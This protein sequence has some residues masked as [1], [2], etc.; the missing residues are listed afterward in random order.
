MLDSMS[1]D[2]PIKLFLPKEQ[3]FLRSKICA[4]NH[5]IGFTERLPK[6]P[7]QLSKNHVKPNNV[8][9]E[10]CHTR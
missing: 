4:F 9:P 10:M 2:E 1:K 5:L 6:T 7:Q 3:L 8:F